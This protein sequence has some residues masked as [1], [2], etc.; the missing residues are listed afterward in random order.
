MRDIMRHGELISPADAVD[1][2]LDPLACTVVDEV[3]GS[4]RG[5]RAHV[6][7]LDRVALRR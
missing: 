4:L 7:D 3:L 2:S 6:E 1:I 5:G